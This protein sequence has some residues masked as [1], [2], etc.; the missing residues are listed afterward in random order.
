[1]LVRAA[2]INYKAYLLPDSYLN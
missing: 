1:M 2:G